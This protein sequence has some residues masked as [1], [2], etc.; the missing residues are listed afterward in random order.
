MNCNNCETINKVTPAKYHDD[1]FGFLCEEC[2][3]LIGG[4]VNEELLYASIEDY[5]ENL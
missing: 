4:A 3:A 2:E 1:D 5:P